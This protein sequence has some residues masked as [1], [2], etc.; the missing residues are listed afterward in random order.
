MPPENVHSSQP[1]SSDRRTP[2]H[3]YVHFTW[4]CR[5]GDN[6]G[7]LG[8][9]IDVSK[10]GAAFLTLREVA[11]DERLLLVMVTPHGRVSSLARVVHVT[12]LDATFRVGV[13]IEVVP[14]TDSAAWDNLLSKET[15]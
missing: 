8:H 2:R 4:F 11:A 14:P 7:H 5:V 15:P 1:P 3:P 10:N 6:A 9:T 13:A 12:K